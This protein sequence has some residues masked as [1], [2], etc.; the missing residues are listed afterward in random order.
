MGKGARFGIG[1]TLIW[2]GL[3]LTYSIHSIDP[4][5]NTPFAMVIGSILIC[6]GAIMIGRVIW[7]PEEK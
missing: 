2:V 5:D 4:G 3:G 6:P 7:P 1:I